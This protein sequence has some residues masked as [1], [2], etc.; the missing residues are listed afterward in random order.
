MLKNWWKIHVENFCYDTKDLI[1]KGSFGKVYRGRDKTVSTSFRHRN[2]K[3][4]EFIPA[5]EQVHEV[6]VEF[7]NETWHKN[8]LKFGHLYILITDCTC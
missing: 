5:H 7:L 8:R 2:L 1:G 6:S 4:E 3:F